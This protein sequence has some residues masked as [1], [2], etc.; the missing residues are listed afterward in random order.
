MQFARKRQENYESVR[1]PHYG[2]C[3]EQ[4]KCKL[5]ADSEVRMKSFSNRLFTGP[6]IPEVVNAGFYHTGTEDILQCF[7]CGLKLK[8]WDKSDNPWSEHA[9]HSN[10]CPYIINVK[11]KEFCQFVLKQEQQDIEHDSASSRFTDDLK[12]TIAAQA[13]LKMN[14]Y[15]QEHIMRA[16][17]I[18]V[19]KNGTVEFSAVEIAEIIH[20]EL[21][22][23]R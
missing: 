20:S 9:R 6:N 7:Q 5:F 16:I 10:K 22:P 18:F 21:T 4:P 11:G 17:K 15:K 23:Q 13:L 19:E 14:C 3:I 12:F 2:V 1:D 8:N